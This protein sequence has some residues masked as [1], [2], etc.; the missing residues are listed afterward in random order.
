MKWTLIEALISKSRKT[1][2]IPMFL[3]RVDRPL[4]CKDITEFTGYPAN[5]DEL[6]LVGDQDIYWEEGVKGRASMYDF[7]VHGSPESLRE[8]ARFTCR[9]CSKKY[10]TFQFT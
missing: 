8:I 5:D 6:Y 7:R 1:P 10:F 4:C 2:D 9:H 3:Q